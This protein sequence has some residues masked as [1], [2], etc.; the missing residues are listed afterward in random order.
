MDRVGE[1]LAFRHSLK[2]QIRQCRL[3]AFR[4][5]MLAHQQQKCHDGPQE[6]NEFDLRAPMQGS[7]SVD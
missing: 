5:P 7:C 3:A 1:R 4:C 6:I 2:G